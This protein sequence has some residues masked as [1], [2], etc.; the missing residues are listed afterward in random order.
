MRALPLPRGTV[1]S[2]ALAFTLPLIACGGDERDK[3][4]EVA[5]EYLAAYAE[6]DADK[7]CD[8]SAEQTARELA[9]NIGSRSCEEGV[10]HSTFTGIKPRQ[11]RDA[12]VQRV[13]LL[14]RTAFVRLRTAAFMKP[15]Y[16]Q[17]ELQPEGEEWRV[18]GPFG[19]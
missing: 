5:E 3:A 7:V 2:S 10:S 4:R 13:T 19:D 16:F 11:L 6:A 9:E 1:A 17:V 12:E 14:G 8:L 15:P 18:K